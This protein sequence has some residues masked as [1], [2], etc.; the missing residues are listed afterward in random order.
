M[1]HIPLLVCAMVQSAFITC[2]CGWVRGDITVF[3]LY[4]SLP[5]VCY[6]DSMASAVSTTGCKLLAQFNMPM[7]TSVCKTKYFI[8]THTHTHPCISCI[9]CL[10]SHVIKCVL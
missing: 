9:T 6:G 7:C 5:C 2:V 8:Y 4:R 10:D 1:L 3:A